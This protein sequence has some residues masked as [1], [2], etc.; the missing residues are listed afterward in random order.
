V[1]PVPAT[2][3][4]PCYDEARRLD[5]DAFVAFVERAGTE[6]LFV[7][8]GSRDDTAAVLDRM[9][10]RAPERIRSLGLSRNAG[11]GEAV[12]AGMRDAMAHG[13]TVV[14]YLDA[15]L[16][17]PLEELE[18][19]LA[20]HERTGADVVLGSRVGLLGWE[21]QRSAHR[22]YMG[23]VFATAASMVLR[24]RVYDTQCGAKVF[25][26]SPALEDALADA[27]RSRWIFDVEL[28]GRLRVANPNIRFLEVPLRRWSDVT[29][30]KLLPGAMTLAVRDLVTIHRDLR[31]RE[32]R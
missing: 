25:S 13:A 14:G 21:I 23:R 19:L 29:G 2:V 22:H 15:D 5:A 24:L 10:S 18:R 8:D 7:D 3:V 20:E 30:S 11:K 16:S 27:F 32:G 6:L 17:T 9:A 4:V 31:R 12:R 26:V 28:L 1:G